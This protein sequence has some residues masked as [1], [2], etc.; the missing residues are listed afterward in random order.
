MAQAGGTSSGGIVTDGLIFHL[1]GVNKGSDDG[2]WIDQVN[3][4]VYSGNA[5]SIENGFYFSDRTFLSGPNPKIP[6]DGHTMEFC[7]DKLLIGNFRIFDQGSST[8]KNLWCVGGY[9]KQLI[10][11][12][13]N[14]TPYRNTFPYVDAG[15]LSFR[16]DKNSIQNLKNVSPSS[17]SYW[18]TTETNTM[19]IGVSKD[20]GDPLTGALF[21]L[22]FYNRILTDEEILQNQQYDIDTYFGGVIP[23]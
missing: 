13:A 23:E 4:L 20:R 18:S 5:Q 6:I 2:T 19:T 17:P 15:T 21:E 9:F 3:G 11:G 22:R 14:A 12:T 8:G 1:S 10:L 7:Y 16:E